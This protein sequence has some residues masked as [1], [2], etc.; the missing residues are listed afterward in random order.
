MEATKVIHSILKLFQLKDITIAT[1]S[2]FQLLNLS[3]TIAMIIGSTAFFLL[4]IFYTYRFL[5]E[6]LRKS[7]RRLFMQLSLAGATLFV[8]GVL[9]GFG[10]LYFYLSSIAGV[11]L[12]IGVANVWDVGTFLSQMIVTSIFLGFIF[13]FPIILTFLIRLRIVTVDFLRKKRKV[14]LILIFI[15]VGFL[16]PPDIFSTLIEAF[17]LVLLYEI[18]LRANEPFARRQIAKA[19]ETSP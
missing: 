3:T 9:Y 18:A 12:G 2:P 15:V 1:T 5:K 10:I 7:E 6:G 16:P 17:P 13:Q 11:N 4:V 19:Q 14:A 8:V